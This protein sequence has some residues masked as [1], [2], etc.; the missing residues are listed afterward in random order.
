MRS[1]LAD[2]T[3][4]LGPTPNASPKWLHHSV[5]VVL[6]KDKGKNIGDPFHFD[7]IRVARV[8]CALSAS[9]AAAD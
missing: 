9:E 3:L 8:I 7:P 5:L 6:D 4:P 1:A 2:V